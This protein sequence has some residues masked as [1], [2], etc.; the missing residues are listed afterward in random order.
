[1]SPKKTLTLKHIDFLTLLGDSKN[2]KRRNALIDIATNGEIDSISECILNIL[3][4][5]VPLKPFQTKKLQKIKKYLRLLASKKCSIK[6]RKKILKQKGGFLG[7]LIP[8]AI[9]AISS[10]LGLNK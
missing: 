1:M 9:A 5:K 10:L 2:K 3:Q 8:V 4:G 7:A 6:N